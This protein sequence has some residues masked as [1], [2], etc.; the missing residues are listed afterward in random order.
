M[1]EK[2]DRDPDTVLGRDQGGRHLPTREVDKSLTNGFWG[3]Q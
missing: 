1:R 2:R 3:L